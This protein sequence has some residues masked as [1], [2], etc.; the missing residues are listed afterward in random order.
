MQGYCLIILFMQ[1]VNS[2]NQLTK[3][4]TAQSNK[5]TLYTSC[6]HTATER[7]AIDK[8]SR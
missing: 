1:K 6:H 7:E 2:Q 8:V 5:A 3:L 4:V